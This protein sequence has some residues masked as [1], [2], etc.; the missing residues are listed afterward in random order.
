MSGYR[1]MEVVCRT[2][3]D[4][5]GTGWF[6]GFGQ[7]DGECCVIIENSDGQVIPYPLSGYWPRFKDHNNLPV[8]SVPPPTTSLSR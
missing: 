1:V 6:H 3:G 5:E 2:T 7:V 4:D 8:P